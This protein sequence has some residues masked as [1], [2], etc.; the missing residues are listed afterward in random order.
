MVHKWDICTLTDLEYVHLTPRGNHSLIMCCNSMCREIHKAGS[1]VK[2]GNN[3]EANR[4]V[5][6]NQMSSS[7]PL[8]GK[9]QTASVLQSQVGP[10]IRID[11]VEDA[12]LLVYLVEEEKDIHIGVLVLVCHLATHLTTRDQPS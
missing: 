12:E 5:G 6:V 4:E 9:C 7:S 10:A 8:I 2:C 3:V 11:Q 1:I